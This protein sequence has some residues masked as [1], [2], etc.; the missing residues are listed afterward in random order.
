VPS[1]RESVFSPAKVRT[2]KTKEAGS[3]TAGLA[4]GYEL[5]SSAEQR[6]RS[7]N[8]PHLVRLIREGVRFKDGRIIPSADPLLPPLQTEGTAACSA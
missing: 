4:M 6:W 2:K 7:V 1:G 8:E 5:V 3:R